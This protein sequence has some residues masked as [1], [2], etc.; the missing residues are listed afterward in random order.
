[1]QLFWSKKIK[2][3]AIVISTL[4][5]SPSAF[6]QIKI[7]LLEP[8]AAEGSQV[9]TMQK[10]IVRGE[11]MD[12]LVNFSGYEAFTRMDIDQI[13]KEQ[14]FQRTGLV[15]NDQIKKV[16]EMSG[17]D[18]ICVSK[19][20]K[21]NDEVY[22][23]AYLI[24][25]ETGQISN[26]ATQY[27]V[28]PDGKLSNMV[29]I[30]RALAEELI[31]ATMSSRIKFIGNEFTETAL[32]VNMKMIYVEGG[33]FEMGCTGDDSLKI[34]NDEANLRRKT[35]VSSFYIGMLEVTQKQWY[36][37]MGHYD[38]QKI[39]IDL[40]YE[41]TPYGSY[42]SPNE[43]KKIEFK[44]KEDDLRDKYYN[45]LYDWAETV[46]E[47]G[48]IGIYGVLGVPDEPIAVGDQYPMCLISHDEVEEFLLKLRD[49]SGKKYYL[50]TEAQ[51]EYAAR[52]G[53]KSKTTNFSG[54]NKY[55]DVGYS[56]SSYHV[57]GSLKPNELGIYDMSGNV[58]E[59]CS[60]LY[61]EYYIQYDNFDPQGPETPAP[62]WFDTPYVIRG[63]DWMDEKK[64]KIID[65]DACSSIWQSP[66]VGFRVIC[67][68]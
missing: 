9:S 45:I 22:I 18:F 64:E 40:F 42:Y 47:M 33:T 17:A 26:P 29:I 19:L 5:L 8:L 10:N 11:L 3:L 52:G 36:A 21:S 38:P 32:G 54:S 44:H 67:I 65:R 63:G 50:P 31:G 51:W 7:A 23:E 35:T 4:I 53:N 55:E 68:P 56:D 58:S 16:G 6:S 49:A 20:S 1:M 60:D 14:D 57:C 41:Y 15:N 59:M 61:D 34:C 12:A 13:M 46:D 24:N 37:V 25:V 2:P 30:C 66:T 28:L 48:E 39:D 62:N 27:G 43:I